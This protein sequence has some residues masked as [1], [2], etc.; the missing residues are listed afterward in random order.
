MGARAAD[1]QIKGLKTS[2]TQREN[3]RRL[4]PLSSNISR[5]KYERNTDLFSVS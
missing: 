4:L 1:K 2:G 3:K 5:L